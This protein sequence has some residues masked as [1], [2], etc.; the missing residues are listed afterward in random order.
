MKTKEGSGSPGLDNDG[1]QKI[2][3]SASYGE[4]AS[5]VCR[6]VARLIRKSCAKTGFNNFGSFASVSLYSFG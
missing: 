4:S 6:T 2:L 5:N 1:W 3:T